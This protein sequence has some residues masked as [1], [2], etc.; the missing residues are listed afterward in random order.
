MGRKT[1]RYRQPL[2]WVH[3]G[4]RF[5]LRGQTPMNAGVIIVLALGAVIAYANGA[6]DVSKSIATLVGSGVANYKKAI[7]WGALW[8]GVG[9]LAGFTLAGAMTA[10]FGKGLLNDGVVPSFA[11]VIAT[12]AGATLWVLLANRIGMPVSTTHA[13]VGAIVGVSSTAYGLEGVRWS[14]LG[15]KILLPLLA[16]PVV[17]IALTAVLIRTSRALASNCEIPE[18]VC[19]EF[20]TSNVVAVAPGLAALSTELSPELRVTWAPQQNC[21]SER[22]KAARLT[23]DHLHWF[24]S[25]GTAFARGLNDAPKMAAL[26][27]AASFLTN[28]ASLRLTAFLVITCAMVMGSLIAGRIVTGVLS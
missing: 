1:D 10:T 25:G 7:A 28:A 4:K 6:N 24:T 12:L 21:A 15:L 11:P 2:L 23:M 18:C 20:A 17:A 26:V 3:G 13:I 8:T 22:P 9:G 5:Q 14:T 19:A 27:I 16:S